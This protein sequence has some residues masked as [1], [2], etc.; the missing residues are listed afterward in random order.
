MARPSILCKGGNRTLTTGTGSLTQTGALSYFM[1]LFLNRT[2]SGT[3]VW[4][5]LNG[6]Q[7][8]NSRMLHK[9]FGSSGRNPFCWNHL[10]GH[11]DGG[12]ASSCHRI[13][14]QSS[15]KRL[16]GPD[17]HSRLDLISNRSHA[18]RRLRARINS[19]ACARESPMALAAR[20]TT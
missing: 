19:P 14:W 15:A 17:Q 18:T 13:H 12:S 5:T 2:C 11:I 4:V 1:L 3:I 20:Y 9:S 8:M 10:S 6:A 7:Q 16:V